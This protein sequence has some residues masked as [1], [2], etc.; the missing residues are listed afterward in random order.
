MSHEMFFPAAVRGL[1]LPAREEPTESQLGD[2][3]ER[4]HGVA[5]HVEGAVEGNLYGTTLTYF[6]KL[7]RLQRK[8][9]SL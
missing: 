1:L 2:G 5:G 7:S 8:I 4:G 9:T 6:V 3:L